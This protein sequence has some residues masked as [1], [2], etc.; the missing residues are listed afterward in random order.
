MNVKVSEM[1]E[2]LSYFS[3]DDLIAFDGVY[4]S[5]IT[6]LCKNKSQSGYAQIQF[7]KEDKD[8]PVS[9]TIIGDIE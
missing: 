2:I 6:V 9:F 1:K 4:K 5:S 8:A 3:D 7:R